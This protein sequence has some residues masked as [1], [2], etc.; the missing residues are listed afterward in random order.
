VAD[1]ETSRLAPALTGSIPEI[2]IEL[3]SMDI[4]RETL[5][6]SI[7]RTHL[8]DFENSGLL[9]PAPGTILPLK[10]VR[11]NAPR[12][13]ATTGSEVNELTMQEAALRTV[14]PKKVSDR[15]GVRCEIP[16]PGPGVGS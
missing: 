5:W 2:G 9:E 13:Q 12:L 15:A 1:Q 16:T 7:R 3:G 8:Q 11:T 4:A 6:D 10:T 14:D